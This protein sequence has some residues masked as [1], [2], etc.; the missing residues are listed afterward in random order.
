MFTL[1]LKELPRE[2]VF[3]SLRK[4]LHIGL[5]SVFL[6]LFVLWLLLPM[7]YFQSIARRNLEFLKHCILH[8]TLN[9]WLADEVVWKLYLLILQNRELWGIINIPSFFMGL[10]QVR[11]FLLKI[12]LCLPLSVLLSWLSF[13]FPWEQYYSIFRMNF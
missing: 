12:I 5:S 8:H 6:L 10:V 13:P 2:T 3:P 11:G 9:Q 7:A 4:L 1:C